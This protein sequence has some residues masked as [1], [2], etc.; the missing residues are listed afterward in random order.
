MKSLPNILT[1][2]RLVRTATELGFEIVTME[3]G[4]ARAGL[5]V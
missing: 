2:A 1:G 3:Q 5:T 4:A